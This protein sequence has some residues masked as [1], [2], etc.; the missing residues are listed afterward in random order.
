M[1]TLILIAATLM[2]MS[3]AKTADPYVVAKAEYECRNHGGLYAIGRIDPHALCRNGVHR[4][5]RN[6]VIADPKYYPPRKVN[7]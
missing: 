7:L 2:L 6:T 1:K 5:I 3:C 4:S